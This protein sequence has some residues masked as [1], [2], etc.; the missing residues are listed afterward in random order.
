MYSK[1]HSAPRVSAHG[2]PEAGA[3]L[4]DDDQLAGLQLALRGGADQVECARLG[5][6]HP[7]VVQ[8]ADHQRADAV[9]VAEPGQGAR[10][11]TT[12]A[13]APSMRD[14]VSATASARSPDGCWAMSAA[15]TSVSEVDSQLYAALAQL[16][17]QLDGVGQVA[18]VAQ[19]DRAVARPWRTIGWAFCHTVE[20]VVE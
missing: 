18:V 9:R 5:G 13:N 2:L 7:G 3:L 11:E 15:M 16:V 4:V 8:P 10:V 6:Q 19:G 17:A 20:P 14:I 1:M 12:A